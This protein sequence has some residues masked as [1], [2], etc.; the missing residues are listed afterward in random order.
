MFDLT[1]I[2]YLNNFTFKQKRRLSCSLPHA[3]RP[4]AGIYSSKTHKKA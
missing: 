3:F 2:L 1:T 4:L